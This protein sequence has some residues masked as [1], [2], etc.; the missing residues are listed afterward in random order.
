MPKAEGSI[1]K[2]AIMKFLAACQCDNMVVAAALREWSLEYALKRKLDERSLVRFQGIIASDFT[3]STSLDI[4]KRAYRPQ[5]L[6]LIKQ[7]TQRV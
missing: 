3:C 2:S 6:N 7:N 4:Q 1:G 5:L